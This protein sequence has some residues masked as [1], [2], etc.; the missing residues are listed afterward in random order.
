MDENG[1]LHRHHVG[2]LWIACEPVYRDWSHPLDEPRTWT[3]LFFLDDA[4]ALA[5]G[6][7][8]CGLCR[9]SDYLSFQRAATNSTESE[10][11]LKAPEL[12]AMLAT[13]RLRKGR[14]L[15]R[16][17]DRIL[18]SAAIDELPSGTVILDSLTGDP[19]LVTTDSIQKF[20]FDGWGPPTNR[21]WGI[22]VDVLTPPTSIRALNSGFKP[23]MHE[24]AIT[25]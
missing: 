11:L 20:T 25:S 12:N 2:S 16:R 3:P 7:R 18:W 9:R 22:T 14:G 5:A 1:T 19:L 10:H 17:D 23:R 13:E 21:P 6:H 15:E 24:T 8:P 4:V